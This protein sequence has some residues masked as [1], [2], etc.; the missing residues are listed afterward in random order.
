MLLFIRNNRQ[1]YFNKLLESIKDSLYRKERYEV[2]FALAIAICDTEIDMSDFSHDIRKTDIFTV[3]ENHLCSVV[4]EAVTVDSAIKA[5][6]NLQTAF[7]A[8]YFQ[9]KLFIS[10]VTSDDD[11]YNNDGKK[12]INSLLDALEYSIATNKNH[13]VIDYYQMLRCK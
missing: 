1:K 12:M 3:L 6:A 10:I 8:K 2:D 4:F 9:K 5:T 13:E 11:N 7:E